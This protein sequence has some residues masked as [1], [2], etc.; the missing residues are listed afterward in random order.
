MWFFLLFVLPCLAS[1]VTNARGRAYL[2]SRQ[3]RM[4]A[5][6]FRESLLESPGKPSL[7]LGLGRSL[8]GMGRCEEA[9]PFL[10][11]NRVSL[12][13]GWRAAMALA[14]CHEM[15]GAPQQALYF[16]DEASRMRPEGSGIEL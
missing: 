1:P 15:N 2:D 4:A 3:Y 7:E 13:Y 11:R 8:A 5:Q 12:A 6:V 14:S 9:L 16:L 10:E